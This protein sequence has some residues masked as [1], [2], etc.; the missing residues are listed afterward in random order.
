MLKMRVFLLVL[1]ISLFPIVAFAQEPAA[2]G[3]D[4]WI[5]PGAET[6]LYSFSTVACGGSLAIAY[7]KGTS[8]GF[9]AAYFYDIEGDVDTL[10]LSFLLRFYFMG[11][12]AGPFI[13]LTG[14][15]ALFFKRDDGAAFPADWGMISGGLNLGWRFLMGKTLFIEPSIRAGYPYVAG[16]SLATGARF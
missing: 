5:C 1:C 6:A 11:G 14:G 10:E 9:K 4:L 7:G 12:G 2:E 15:P 8:I 3:G 13:Q 16:V